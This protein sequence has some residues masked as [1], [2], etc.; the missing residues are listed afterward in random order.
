MNTIRRH[1]PRRV[2]PRTVGSLVGVAMLV[3]GG[4][5]VADT[6]DF[7]FGP[8]E[9]VPLIEDL[10]PT[11]ISFNDRNGDGYPDAIVTGRSTDHVILLLEGGPGGSLTVTGQIQTEDQSDWIA[12]G[13]LDGDGD[14]DMVVAMRSIAGLISI[15]EADGTGSYIEPPRQ[16]RAGREVRCVQLE[17]LDG[18]GDLDLLA[19]GHRSEDILAFLGDG[20]GGFE[21]ASRQRLAPWKNGFVFPQS[22]IAA[23][24]ND[25]DRTDVVGISIGARSV[26][27]GIGEGD[28]GF[29]PVRS[30]VAPEVD[31]QVGGCA[32][33]SAADFDGDDRLEFIAPQT[34]WGQQ[35]FIVFQLDGAGSIEST[36]PLMGSPFGIS[37][38]SEAADFDGDGDQDLCIGHAL[39]GVVIFMENISATPGEV[40]FKEPQ[41]F[42]N[43]EFIRHAAAC[44]IDLDGDQD[45]IAL[46]YTGDQILIFRNGAT[47]GFAGDVAPPNRPAPTRA[48]AV[49]PPQ[50]EGTSGPELL[51]ALSR[52]S[53]DEVLEL[54]ERLRR[55]DRGEDQ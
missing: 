46:D 2:D 36:R 43:G 28:G 47:E 52:M 5:G 11:C 14:L 30:W 51:H 38:F 8:P 48:P 6:T 24:L 27:I 32:Y 44:D 20:E 22:L 25:D 16:V 42:F 55:T 7:P 40:A 50:L 31:G 53:P 39:P 35:W 3:F 15:Y 49:T 12:E 33:I 13:D 54:A 9:V 10:A 21:R 19:I 26:H 34:T 23:D 17:D 4:T 1:D 45:L 18:D 29:E 41:W 37:W